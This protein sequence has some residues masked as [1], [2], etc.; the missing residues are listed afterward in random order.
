[1]CGINGIALSSNSRRSIDVTELERMRDVLIHRGPDDA[2][3]FVDARV[4]RIGLG[5]RRLSIVDVASGQ[6]PMTNEDG[7]LHIV[8]NGEIY[9]HTGFRASLEERGHVYNTH[10]DTETILHLYE[11]HGPRCVEH[12]R[13]MFAFAI[14]DQ[15]KR[16]LF[17]ARDRLGVKPLYYAQSNDG[18]LYFGSEIKA[19]LETGAIRA[20]MN[21]SAL[22]DY[23]AN[24]APSGE[25]TLFS[26]IKRLLP[27]HTL[28][29]A[30]GKI[31]VERYWD[32]SFQ[33]D[34]NSKR[35]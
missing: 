2:G 8:Y 12:L 17:I 29:W 30:D 19:L 11:E 14:W 4:G 27:G 28:L 3:I 10:C 23:L 21:Y 5:H 32:I 6:Q 25:A 22:P 26:G 7:S 18:S 24:H 9:N 34:E 31:R 13:G 1:M 15:K 35:S 20:E 16:Q 33:R